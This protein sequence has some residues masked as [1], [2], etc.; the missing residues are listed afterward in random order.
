MLLGTNPTAHPHEE[1]GSRRKRR[2]VSSPIPEAY[3]VR[4]GFP[5][6]A[7]EIPNG[8]ENQLR[9]AAYG[10]H[11]PPM[12]TAEAA[13]SLKIEPAMDPDL[14]SK[15]DKDASS[16]LQTEII[17]PSVDGHGNKIRPPPN[18]QSSSIA[19]KTMIAVC[20]G[21]K[22]VSPT[23]QS[24]AFN[25]NTK[26]KKR[27]ITHEDNSK[28]KIVKIKYGSSNESRRIL[29]QKIQE[30]I[31]GTTVE[32]NDE[33]TNPKPVKPTIIS[34][35]THPFF[36]GA[37]GRNKDPKDLHRSMVDGDLTSSSVAGKQDMENGLNQVRSVQEVASNDSAS[38]S[39]PEFHQASHGLGKPRSIRYR[40]AMEPIWPPK[41]MTHVRPL[42]RDLTVNTSNVEF[43]ASSAHRKLKYAKVQVA[44]DREILRSYSTLLHQ[45]AKWEEN[46]KSKTVEK[47]RRPIRKIM[48]R[49]ELQ[50]ATRS[51]LT[52]EL[53]TLQPFVSQDDTPGES[54]ISAVTTHG[55]LLRL[56]KDIYSSSTAFDRFECE[57]HDWVHK[58]APKCAEEVLQ[59]GPEALV[60]RDWLK[61]LTITSVGSGSSE[62][63]KGRDKSVSSKKLNANFKRKKRKRAEEL[64]GFVISSDEEIGEMEELQCPEISDTGHQFSGKKS[65]VRVANISGHNAE[66]QKAA[67]AIVISGP[68]GCGKTAAVYAVA[69]EL[70]FEVFEINSGSRRSG[71]D[72]LEK[73]GDMTKNH[74]VN[75]ACE[76]KEGD[77]PKGISDSAERS[78]PDGELGC[79]TDSKPVLQ[80]QKDFNKKPR[81]RPKIHA[82]SLDTNENLEKKKGKRKEKE[83]EKQREEEKEQE[84]QKKKKQKQS[85]RQSLILLEEVDVLFEEDK[86]FWSTTLD[87]ILHSKRPIIMTCTDERLLP[88]DEMILFALL[89]FTPPPEPLAID[90]LILLASSEGHLLSRE[91]L[92]SLLRSKHFDL[93]ASITE[94]NFFCQMAIGDTKGGLEWML[95]QPSS[96]ETRATDGANLRVVSV[97]T[98]GHNFENAQ[99]SPGRKSLVSRAGNNFPANLRSCNVDELS[100]GGYGVT[101]FHSKQSQQKDK[102]ALQ[103]LVAFEQVIDAF[104]AADTHRFSDYRRNELVC[105]MKASR[106]LI[107]NQTEAVRPNST[108][109]FGEI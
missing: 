45:Q 61:S 89:R 2:R 1:L 105:E 69:R 13:Q 19:P 88:L 36:L 28:P 35:P 95:I 72:I 56:F 26:R 14:S 29:A 64:D 12:G 39:L 65:V 15:T 83:K 67:N 48:T 102:Q 104:S 51:L 16:L 68:H 70:D 103:R 30:I 78:V 9:A 5:R 27:D 75:Q 55:A 34:K 42:L 32:I 71:K 99:Q 85:Q 24:L 8:W 37:I 107:L 11:S 76:T 58:Y 82:K 97:E 59:S 43:R 52:S 79:R 18:E 93:R 96:A 81:G 7:Q 108:R 3:A 101:P 41:E 46:I 6:S 4:N 17:K 21:G 54:H 60:L 40:G 10:E 87:L 74:L 22:L 49:S 77:L 50:A 63:H 73:V 106:L 100:C 94:L 98:Y 84:K 33:T 109:R 47:L 92:S 20:A 57:T 38:A 25:S 90:Y 86:Q 23:S 66:G 53:S 91:P 62:L 44:G 31:S 80:S